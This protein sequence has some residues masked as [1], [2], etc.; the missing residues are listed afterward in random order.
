MPHVLISDPNLFFV[1]RLE[2]SLQ[3]A[4]YETA[5]VHDGETLCERLDTGVVALLVGLGSDRPE[6]KAIV[7]R[8]RELMGPDWPIV[9]YGPHVQAH[10][11]AEGREAGCT[12][13]VANGKMARDAAAVV[14]KYVG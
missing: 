7:S 13:F 14:Q 5:L 4:G 2:A 10:L 9:A 6:W 1:S 12:A 11:P 3:A 8:A